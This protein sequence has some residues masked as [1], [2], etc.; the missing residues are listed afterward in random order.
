[1]NQSIQDRIHQIECKL[2]KIRYDMKMQEIL[3]NQ[4]NFTIA[5]SYQVQ[6]KASWL[7]RFEVSTKPTS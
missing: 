2:L 4:L 1:M 5:A 6:A 3:I 7:D